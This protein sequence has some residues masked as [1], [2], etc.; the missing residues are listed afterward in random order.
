ANHLLDVIVTSLAAGVFFAFARSALGNRIAWLATL[1]L[2]GY[3]QLIGHA[4]Y[5]PKDVPVLVASLCMFAALHKLLVS[6]A[7]RWAVLAGFLFGVSLAAKLSAVALLPAL[8]VIL[9]IAFMKSLRAAPDRRGDVAK[10]DGILLA[11]CVVFTAIGTFAAWPTLWF[12][13]LLIIDSLH[14]FLLESF[15]PGKVLYFG[16]EYA[17]ADLPWHYIPVMFFIATPV[18]TLLCFA[19]GSVSAT[20]RAIRS[21]RWQIYVIALAWFFVP[22]LLTLKPGLVR[23][24]GIRQL[25]FC[26]PALALLAGIGFD[27]LLTFASARLP[28]KPLPLVLIAAVVLWTGME[29]VRVFPFE[30]SYVNE[31]VRLAIPNNIDDTFEIEAW[32][33]SYRQ[34]HDWIADNVKP[35]EIVCVPIA[36]YL[37]TW[38]VWPEGI[39]FGCT[40]EARYV[41]FFTRYS[42]SYRTRFERLTPVY[43]IRRYDSPLLLI[44][45]VKPR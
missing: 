38:Y 43:E 3:P 20:R 24:D 27:R 33:A 17:G 18:L 29:I 2:A 32:G 1:F 44:Y 39:R 41:M 45:D 4:Q 26:I 8:L 22:L 13:P 16:T 19:A 35:G 6:R 25:L 23:Y 36:D 21:D 28:W 40:D 11:L 9:G 10:R 12:Q 37:V 7:K 31:T 42:K 15:W 30:G 5:N 34:A 14:V